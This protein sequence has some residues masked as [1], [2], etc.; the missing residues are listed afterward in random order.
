MQLRW[1]QNTWNSKEV[2]FNS[3]SYQ[4]YGYFW[5]EVGQMQRD[6]GQMQT[7]LIFFFPP[8]LYTDLFGTKAALEESFSE[9]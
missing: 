1:P 6:C 7:F 3:H 9:K 5:K 8:V 4:K 2:N